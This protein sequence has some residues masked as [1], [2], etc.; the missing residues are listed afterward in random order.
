MSSVG[1]SNHVSLSF[2]LFQPC[3]LILLSTLELLPLFTTKKCLTLPSSKTYL[4]RGL[5][6]LTFLITWPQKSNV[7]LYIDSELF[8]SCFEYWH[9]LFL[10]KTWAILYIFCPLLPPQ[11]MKYESHNEY[12]LMFIKHQQVLIISGCILWGAILS[13]NSPNYF[14]LRSNTR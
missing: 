14:V 8:S 5:L 13:N 12:L 6:F 10:L 4:I 9:L 7:W 2:S 11:C 1:I 3:V